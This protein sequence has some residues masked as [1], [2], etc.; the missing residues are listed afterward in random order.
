[1]GKL[2]FI[3][4]LFFSLL[5]ILPVVSFSQ[6]TPSKEE[7]KKASEH[8]EKL[9]KRDS[10][11]NLIIQEL[12]VELSGKSNKD[13]IFKHTVELSPKPDAQTKLER[14]LKPRGGNEKLS[15]LGYVI[16][17]FV[18]GFLALFTPCV[19]P[20]IPM[21]V[22]FFTSSSKSRAVAVKKALI[23]GFSIILLYFCVGLA[24]GPTLASIISTHWLPNVIFSLV[25]LVFA[26]SFLGM[27]E[28]TL[29]SALVNKM[30]QQ[31]DRGGYYGIFF[32]AVTLVL[33]SFSCTVPIIGNVLVLAWEHGEVLRPG[34]GML[35]Y[36]SAFAIPF[37]LFALFPSLLNKLPK[38][39]GWLNVIKVILGF[40]ELALALKFISIADQVYHWGILD[41]EVYIAFWIV[42]SFVLG[43]YLLGKF[44]LPHDSEVDKIGV[45][46][47]IL[48]IFS[49]SFA[50]YLVPGLFGAPLKSLAGY[51]PPMST[52]D[53]DLP[54]IV[55]E[56]TS[57]HE[58]YVCD[59][60]K[61][62]SPN[63]KMPH[64]LTGYYTYEQAVACAKQRN[65]P[66]LL[67]FTGHGCVN[68]REM[69]ATVWSD[70]E[71]LKILSN[72][73]IIAS[74]YVDD[75]TKLDSIDAIPYEGK[76]ITLGQKNALLQIKKYNNNA[77]PLYVLV[78]PFTGD[79]LAEPV[80]H[81][82]SVINYLDFLNEGLSN[83]RA[84]H[85]KK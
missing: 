76:K 73:Y 34:L 24:F 78:D 49:F 31:A 12:K 2:K 6:G 65:M 18:S 48:A 52:H 47:L 66:L 62:A 83:F 25:F 64:G 40:V 45:P 41:R 71:V 5:F 32:M 57:S 13:T 63:K 60:P 38:S 54:G 23:Y 20:M 11:N 30:D 44:K 50:V 82:L 72:E 9:I 56:Y 84:D 27:F 80:A 15:L 77:Q 37:T 33:V 68:C 7:L 74:L 58:A 39:G 16:F 21:T 85:P 81:D 4:S 29:P 51:L 42:L 36:S 69:E 46:R 55:R 35:A 3:K 19:F 53:F 75:R 22:T 67:D 43:V 61:Y 17:A 59:E 70:P 28:I 8:I 1:M 10:L 79:K 14:K 26:F